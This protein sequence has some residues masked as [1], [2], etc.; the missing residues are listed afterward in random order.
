MKRILKRIGSGIPFLFLSFIGGWGLGAFISRFSFEM[1]YW[2][3]V[4]IRAG[5]HIAGVPEP[6][7]PDDIETIGLFCLLLA[8]WVVSAAVL[9]GAW[10]LVVRHVRKRRCANGPSGRQR[11]GQ[12]HEP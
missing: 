2:L 5:M 9:G 4:T 1:P 6:L 12:R 11:D 7:D 10:T 8:C 3:D